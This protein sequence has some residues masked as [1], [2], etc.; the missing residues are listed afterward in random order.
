VGGAGQ[1]VVRLRDG[2]FLVVGNKSIWS[3]PI[4]YDEPRAEIYDGV[5]DTWTV[6]ARP[7][8]NGEGSGAALLP[9]GRVLVAG[10]RPGGA[11][12]VMIDANAHRGVE[13]FDPA[14]GIW[15][16]TGDPLRPRAY[17]SQFV[18]LPDGRIAAVGGS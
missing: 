16:P 7:A 5:S 4:Y 8:Y 18:T 12:G 9:D 2:R 15:S 1:A 13:M 11:A 10:G 14:T 6:V 3:D 17:S